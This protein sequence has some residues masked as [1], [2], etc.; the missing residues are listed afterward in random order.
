MIM[1]K[2]LTSL[3]TVDE[4]N[5]YCDVVMLGYNALLG[6]LNI[7]ALLYPFLTIL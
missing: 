3:L 7:N 5:K 4:D 6:V 2:D 1:V